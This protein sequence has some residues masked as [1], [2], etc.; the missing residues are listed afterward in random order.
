MAF[1]VEVS[2]RAFE[3]LDA[4]AGYITEH[5]SFERA[6]KWFNEIIDAVALLKDM[7]RRCPVA[8][9]SEELGREVRF[10][11]HGRRN[12]LYKVYFSVHEKTQASG[13]V[14]VLHVRHWA[15][16]GLTAQEL[17]EILGEAQPE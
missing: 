11:L 4:I 16:R 9:E 15:Q 14:Q 10:L 3:D 5:D 1:R 13:T 6:Q 12:H 2:P 7:P 8:G 17:E